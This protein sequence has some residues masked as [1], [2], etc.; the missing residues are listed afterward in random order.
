MDVARSTDAFYFFHTFSVAAFGS[1]SSVGNWSRCNGIMCLSQCRNMILKTRIKSCHILYI[2]LQNK[3]VC[4]SQCGTV[5]MSPPKNSQLHS[6][7]GMAE[8][9][10]KRFRAMSSSPSVPALLCRNTLEAE[11]TSVSN[12]QRMEHVRNFKLTFPEGTLEIQ[13]CAVPRPV[14]QHWCAFEIQPYNILQCLT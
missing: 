2:T 12:F 11:V 1:G 10:A 9:A 5:Y 7:S 6:A 3:A 8:N 4:T 14:L 13:P